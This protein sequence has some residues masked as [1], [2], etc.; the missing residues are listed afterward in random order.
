MK[1]NTGMHP[2]CPTGRTWSAID[3]GLQWAKKSVCTVIS[4]NACRSQLLL[5][6]DTIFPA[7]SHY[8]DKQ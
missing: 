1:S 7:I 4:L 5:K 3:G 8:R 2:D 6:F